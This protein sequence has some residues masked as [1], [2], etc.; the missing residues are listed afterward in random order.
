MIILVTILFNSAPFLN[1][2]IKYQNLI[3]NYVT[4]FLGLTDSFLI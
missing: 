1:D 3:K 4:I 2:K